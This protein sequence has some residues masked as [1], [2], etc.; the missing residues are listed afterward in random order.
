MIIPVITGNQ[1]PAYET[2][3]SAGMDV[4]ADFWHIVEKFLF[5]TTINR[6]DSVYTDEDGETHT[7]EAIDSLTILPGGRALIPT[8]L[9]VAVPEGYE[10]QVRPRSGLALKNGITVLNTPGT[11]DA[12]YRGEIGVI[13]INHGTEP[14]TIHADDRI[15]QLVLNKVEKIEWQHVDALP[16]TTR[17]EGGF[18]STGK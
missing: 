11:I 1:L 7:I 14:F 15:G 17:G 4:R 10:I 8:N 2:P 13:L 9:R 12:D 3:A 18:G 6:K 5:N 16:E